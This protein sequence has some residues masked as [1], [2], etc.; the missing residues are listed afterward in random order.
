MKVRAIYHRDEYSAEV[1]RPINE[2]FAEV[3]YGPLLALIKDAGVDPNPADQ[4]GQGNL[5]AKADD[6]GD[7]E[8]FDD[9]L[10]WP[11]GSM[12]QV[13]EE[14][15]DAFIARLLTL[16]VPAVHGY[17]RADTLRPT[18]AVWSPTKVAAIQWNPA[19]PILCARGM[20][21]IDG[22][23]HW[24][25]ALQTSPATKVRVVEFDCDPDALISLAKVALSLTIEN[26]KN[27]NTSALRR[28]LAAGVVWYADGVFTG[29]ISA[30]TARELRAAGAT[31]SE[32]REGFVL[33][34]DRLPNDLKASA[35]GSEGRSRALHDQIGRMLDQM[36]QNIPLSQ[37]GLALGAP[38]AAIAGGLQGQWAKMLDD[39]KEVGEEFEVPTA[40]AQISVSADVTPEIAR[41]LNQQL[42]ENL[43]LTIK[44]FAAKEIPELRRKVAA[45]AFAGGRADRLAKVIEA[46]YGVS[47]RKAAFLAEQETSLLVSKF[48]EQRYREVG[49]PTYKWSTSH[50]ERVRADHRALDGQVFSFDTPP[51]TNRK[52]GARNNPGEDFRCRCVAIP[53]L[54]FPRSDDDSQRSAKRSTPAAH[55]VGV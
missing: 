16:R 37:L 15:R 10:G 14:G 44:D 51:I 3:I 29:R 18:Q 6:P 30:A 48:R 36:Q 49:A 20:R 32:Q 19:R 53:V 55:A 25:R 46:S 31:W 22:H 41:A 33:P 2:W 40:A 11:R 17:L 34:A 8:P 45:N 54:V 4:G 13:S 28:D 38:S 50:D 24:V 9:S 47:K 39:V 43:T 35:L 42:T 27:P 23:H 52:T 5:N 1:E 26:A 21:I 12:P 7:W